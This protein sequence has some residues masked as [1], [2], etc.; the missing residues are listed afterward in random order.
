MYLDSK[1]T[2]S[3]LFFSFAFIIVLT[4]LSNI[5]GFEHLS[6]VQN[7]INQIIEIQNAQIA[8]MN[9]MRSLARERIIKLQAIS[10]EDDPFKQDSIISEFHELGSLFLQNRELLIKTKLTDEETTLLKLQREVA[11]YIVASQYRVIK[12]A[13]EG[14][15]N[16]SV[17][18]LINFIVPKQNENV[19]LMDQFILY[20]NHQNLFLK[21]EAHKK[22]RAAYQTVFFLS[23]F[24][25]LIIIAIAS[26][27]IKNVSKVI[28]IQSQSINNHKEIED[29]L[30]QAQ[31]MLELNVEKHSRNL[32][33]ANFKL[34]HHA[35]HDPLTGLPNRH[36]FYELLSHEIDKAKRNHYN[37]A[38]LSMDLD[39]FKALNDA[40]GHSRGN[41]LLVNV[42]KRLKSSLRK[43]DLIA[44]LGGDEFSICYSNV[45]KNEDIIL[46]CQILI[47]KINQPMFLDQ[48]H[49]NI[50]MSIGVSIY[51][52]HG[53]DYDTLMHVADSNMNQVKRS[54]KNNFSIGD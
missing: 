1:K 36:L 40:L 33:Q 44:R 42:A 8:Y 23:F 46:L 9:K 10:N 2:R 45:K 37:L 17:N 21:S 13:K 29:K 53:T 43:E 16:E 28:K 5:L 52:E 4:I 25:I 38:I 7:D 31:A 14:K 48:H 19:S 18:F 24:S 12:L 49:C 39:G 51:P 32:K 6:T 30:E 22:I 35:D 34:Q 54:G 15:N 50:E 3:L 47:N 41:S 27:V 20:Q 26:I 11:R